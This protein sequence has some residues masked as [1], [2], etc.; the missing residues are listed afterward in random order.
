[1]RRV[2][3]RSKRFSRISKRRG[4]IIPY[5]RHVIYKNVKRQAVQQFLGR[6][7]NAMARKRTWSPRQIVVRKR[8]SRRSSSPVTHNVRVHNPNPCQVQFPNVDYRVQGLDATDLSISENRLRIAMLIPVTSRKMNLGA[9]K[10]LEFFKKVLPTFLNSL[11]QDYCMYDYNFYLGCDQGDVYYDNAQRM[12]EF[13]SIF[14]SVAANY[15]R[16]RLA[17]FMS[18]QGTQS[19]PCYAWNQLFLKAYQDNND[20]FYQIGD[21]CEFVTSGWSSEFINAL[22]THKNELGVAG[23]LDINNKLLMTQSFVSR[24]HMLVFDTYYPRFFRNWFCDNWMVCVYQDLG[25]CHWLQQHKIQNKKQPERYSIH[26]VSKAEFRTE[27]ENGKIKLI[28][29]MNRPIKLSILICTIESRWFYLSRLRHLLNLQLLKF[30]NGTGD[31]HLHTN[32][33]QIEILI[34]YTPQGAMSIGEKRNRLIKNA[35]G[36]FVSFIDDDDLVSQKYVSSILTALE[37]NPS[38]DCI[39]M[40]GLMYKDGRFVKPFLHNTRNKKWTEDNVNFYRPPNHLNPIRKSVS[41]LYPFKHINSGEDRD[42]SLR[43]SS[44]LHHE[45]II[46]EPIYYYL[47]VSKK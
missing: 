14:R 31:S 33:N 6:S 27:V 8:V 44:R 5:R 32:D 36:V 45:T 18:L 24:T 7:E 46:D 19:A 20:Y 12:S 11:G 26:N 10:D 22:R 37:T 16:V 23:P 2:V 35:S 47:Y 28:G 34:D 40:K 39:G 3:R 25:L 21:D 13:S 43:I 41:V 38:V 1:M 42:F 9:T 15:P 4:M 29:W 30:A 17:Q